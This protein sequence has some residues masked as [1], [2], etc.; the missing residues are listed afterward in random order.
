VEF[1]F[2][3]EPPSDHVRRRGLPRPSW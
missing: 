2:D 1:E 3:A